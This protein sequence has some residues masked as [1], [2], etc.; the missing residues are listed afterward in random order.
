MKTEETDNIDILTRMQELSKMIDEQLAQSAGIPVWILENVKSGNLK[1]KVTF[2]KIL[3]GIVKNERKRKGY[4]VKQLA[5]ATLQT[6]ETI[7]EL[8]KGGISNWLVYEVCLEKLMNS[9][10]FVEKDTDK[11]V[12]SNETTVTIKYQSIQEECGDFVRTILQYTIKHCHP[13]VATNLGKKKGIT[14]KI[15]A[16]I[17]KGNV[18]DLKPYYTIIHYCLRLLVYKSGLKKTEWNLEGISFVRFDAMTKDLPGNDTSIAEYKTVFQ[19]LKNV[20]DN[21]G[22]KQHKSVAKTVPQKP[23]GHTIRIHKV[24]HSSGPISQEGN[25][26]RWRTYSSGG[27]FDYGLTDT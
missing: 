24:I 16:E 26:V 22:K 9:N 12:A 14:A 5:K 27:D 18:V 17:I 19:Y 1:N 4:T 10:R 8:E 23:V 2:A 21:N 25:A 11:R 7:E 15:V 3:A 13:R 6:N 20:I